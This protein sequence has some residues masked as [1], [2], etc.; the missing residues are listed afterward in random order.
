MPAKKKALVGLCIFT[1]GFLVGCASNRAPKGWLPDAEHAQIQGFGAWI[2][3]E[4]QIDSSELEAEGEFIAAAEDSI[5]VLTPDSLLAAATNQIIRARLYTYDAQQD[6]LALWT[7]VGSLS[8]VSH[9]LILIFSLPLWVVTGSISTAA[10]SWLPVE[11]SPPKS[12]QEFRKFARFPQ[13]LPKHLDRR[14]LK[15]KR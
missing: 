10:Q 3:I 8:T 12:W 9:G 11:K 2:Q 7:T 13:G 6:K 15:A 5:F 1:A 4:C 14:K